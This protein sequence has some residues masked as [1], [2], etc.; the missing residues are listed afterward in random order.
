MQFPIVQEYKTDIQRTNPENEID[1]EPFA[2]DAGVFN[3][4]IVPRHAPFFVKSLKL[5]HLSG[6]P[7]I[8]DEDYEIFRLMP[9]LTELVG[10]P[11]SCF[12]ALKK[13]EITEGTISYHVVGEFSLIDTAFLNLM[14]QA[15]NDNRPV[16][17]ENVRN[18]P[19]VFPPSLHSHSILY[20]MVGF[21]DTIEFLAELQVLIEQN[22]TDMVLQ[23]LNHYMALVD[24]YIRVYGGM[25]DLFLKNH[26]EAYDAHGLRARD[27]GLDKVS[28]FTTASFADVLQGRNDMH[29]RPQELKTIVEHYGFN[30]DEFLEAK[31]LPVAQFGNT[32]FIP[33]NIDGS[34]EG[35]GGVI[36]TAGM[37]LESDNTIT[38]LWNRMDGRTR[39][40]YFSVITDTNDRD[41][42]KLTYTG[43]K[44]EHPRF[45]PD[46]ANVDRIAQGSGN[47]CILV[48]DSFQNIYYV[49]LTNGSLD[50]S[51]HVYSKV[52]L[53]PLITAI[54][55]DAHLY[56]V[57]DFFQS[58][59]VAL[60]GD[61]VYIVLS[62][63]IG[64]RAP[65]GT[66]INSY[67]NLA[68]K[69]FFR[70]PIA[71][72]KAQI[73]VTAV[74]QNVTFM[75]TDG[76][77]WNNNPWW[78]WYNTVYDGS[79]NVTKG[80]YSYSPRGCNY[81]N[82]IYR[83]T[84]LLVAKNPNVANSYAVKMMAGFYAALVT[85]TLNGQQNAALEVNY[86]FNPY[87]G[88][89]TSLKS[90]TP[91]WKVD[92]T[93]PGNQQ[94]PP[95]LEP[96]LLM[97]QLVFA[98][99]AQGLNILDDGRVIGSG[100]YGFT[101]YP[102][103]CLVQRVT[104]SNS[105]FA[106]IN[107][108]W[109]NGKDI[110]PIPPDAAGIVGEIFS[111]PVE[112]GISVRAPLFTI[113]GEFYIASKKQEST[114]LGVF[115]KTVSGKFALRPDIQNL[116]MSNVVSRPLTNNIRRVNALVGLGGASVIVPSASLNTYGVDVGDS[117]FCVNAQK[118]SFNRELLGN[119]WPIGVA[120]GDIVLVQAHTRRIDADGSITIVPTLEILYP[121]AI[122]NQLKAQ[123]AYLAV[124]NRGKSCHVTISDPT[125]SNLVS[126][127]GW[128]PVTVSIMY[129]DA[130]GNPD[131][132]TL[133]GTFMSIQPTYSV[134]GS[135]R[136][137]TGFT[138]IDK[139]HSYKPSGAINVPRIYGGDLPV[140]ED[141]QSTIGPMRVLYYLD[142]AKLT[143]QHVT[144]V[145]AQLPGDAYV[146]DYTCSY[147]NRNNAS[148]KWD[149]GTITYTERTSRGGGYMAT[150]DNGI[151]VLRGW[152]L[153]TGGA[154]TISEGTVNYP[155]IGSVYPEIGWVIFFKTDINVIFNGTLYVLPLGSID[156]RDIDATPQWK[157]Y[158]VYVILDN[159]VARYDISLDKRLETNY[160]LWVGTVKTN[161]K[162]ILTIERYNVF[163]LDG[164]RVTETKRGNSI[165]ASSGLANTEGQ[166]PWLRT[167]ELLP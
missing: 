153:S 94:T 108:F 101:G 52:D 57:S 83:S 150:P 71:S 127:F 27:V 3:R 86:D 146:H 28:N 128:L 41:K 161:D 78:R 163:A 119:A 126:K 123:V 10:D 34:F 56:K 152:D 79:G 156:L 105:R 97:V 166:I 93:L 42:I 44:Y 81:F 96:G 143:I 160:Q 49:G 6:E 63:N 45:D 98:Y 77:Q 92:F 137:V 82:G 95:G 140:R 114:A 37:C 4:I 17:W 133:Y 25:L 85:P 39:G 15:I 109:E 80:Y 145:V 30:A 1:D 73:D 23:R 151:Q 32:N 66:G 132:E 43:Y 116:F 149:T 115:W 53:R 121:E 5:K 155:L 159:G 20:D 148:R 106:T 142:G 33:P 89:F 36:E 38:V 70:V 139:Y 50:P 69:H 60:M 130:I 87:T 7:M 51:K 141:A 19:S 14:L 107:K 61:W 21:Q 111:S 16:E 67:V 47:E 122:V 99:Q 164:H 46:G 157:T 62:T 104:T 88:V 59:S 165:P 24:W 2:L 158:Y 162:Q 113:G 100:A 84:P 75:D 112:S 9:R 136:I 65:S 138:V 13:P 22:N 110:V 124:A 64:P 129:A 147:A 18:K 31:V 72:I 102:R 118:K 117:Q 74:R 91:T 167:S 55:T 26:E 8:L 68:Y 40:L 35:L 12:I 58:V 76:V 90:R 11:V 29:L 125:Y 54:A 154:A 131:D 120:D 135:R 134:S 103:L 48:G 144:G